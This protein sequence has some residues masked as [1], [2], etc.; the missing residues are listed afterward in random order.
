M[1]A[2]RV[3]GQDPHDRAHRG[4]ATPDAQATIG[5]EINYTV[6]ATIPEGTTLY[7]TPTLTDTFGAR[8]TLLPRTVRPTLNGGAGRAATLESGN[9]I[10]V[11][12]P[13]PYANAAG[14][15]DDMLVLTFSAKVADVA[16]N[17]RGQTLPNTA[18]FT[19]S[20]APTGGAPRTR[21][22]EHEHHDRRAAAP[23]A[24]DENDAD[25]RVAPGQDVALH[26]H[27][28]EPG[29]AARLDRPRPHDGRH[30]PP[31]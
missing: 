29:P 16:A 7:G 31:G 20:D 4:R 17:F 5:E 15:G 28:V 14:S 26:G 9:T 27:A 8:Q 30:L 21:D 12:L 3:A 2:Q 6:T 19:W 11:G 24:K 22:S 23:V 25:D 13:T 1:H 10:T 18:T